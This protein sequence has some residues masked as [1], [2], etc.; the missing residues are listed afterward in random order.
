M[1]ETDSSQGA[2]LSYMLQE[3]LPV[4]LS[5]EWITAA[6]VYCAGK[7]GRCGNGRGFV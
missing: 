6:D 4:R 5:G 7:T 2:S 3:Y 1:D